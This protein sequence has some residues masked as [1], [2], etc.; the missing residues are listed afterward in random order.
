MSCN[1]LSK[2]KTFLS[3]GI[4]DSWIIPRDNTEL[5]LFHSVAIYFLEISALREMTVPF[6]LFNFS[7]YIQIRY[8]ECDHHY[9]VEIWV[10]GTGHMKQ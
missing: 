3:P 9:I 4:V 6:Y 1:R 5:Y 2:V 7:S 10:T 8:C